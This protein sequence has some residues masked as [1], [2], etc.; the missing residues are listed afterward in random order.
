[1]RGCN[2]NHEKWSNLTCLIKL[3]T[4]RQHANKTTATTRY[5]ICSFQASAQRLLQYVRDHWHIE[6]NLHWVLDIAF[7]EDE[8]R[9]RTQH[10][11]QNMATLRHLALNLLKQDQSLKVGLK[12]KRKRA[13]W[14]NCY[15]AHV[16]CP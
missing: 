14:D 13:G 4:I 6:N 1:M 5:F 12:A 3:I 2:H 16:L 7:R 15:L 11:P 9:I 8:S 10:A